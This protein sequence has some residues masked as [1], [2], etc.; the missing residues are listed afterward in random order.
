MN[1]RGFLSV[2]ICL[3]CL[4]LGTGLG[5]AS[6]QQA[7]PTEAKG[8]QAPVVASLALEQS[9][10]ITT[11]Y[12]MT[13]VVLLDPPIQIDNAMTIVNVKP[14]GW[15]KGPKISGKFVSPGADWLR[16]TSSGALRLD[17]RGLIQ[18]D[19]NVFI[20]ISYNGIIQLSN[21]SGE[22]L[23]KGELLTTKDISYLIAAPTFETSS[24][25]YSWLNSIQAVNKCVE[26][27]AGV[28]GYIKYDVFIVR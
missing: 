20:F 24:E 10:E 21:E 25:K 14:G 28:G 19:D 13:C 5:T 6:G 16:V 18:T 12:L 4:A 22:R 26:L 1:R 23:S 2:Y 8:M 15:V 17:V 27:K 11:E 9:T 3:L 7:P